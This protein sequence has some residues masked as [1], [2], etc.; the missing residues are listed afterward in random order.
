MKV[1]TYLVLRQ[2][3]IIFS[4][5]APPLVSQQPSQ[6][7]LEYLLQHHQVN[8]FETQPQLHLLRCP[9]TFLLF[10]LVQDI[11]IKSHVT[12]S[13]DSFVLDISKLVPKHVKIIV[14]EVALHCHNIKLVTLLWINTNI[15]KAT[16]SFQVR[17]L[18]F[19]SCPYLFCQLE[20]QG[21]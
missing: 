10:V 7:F 12:M 16:K 17:V 1:N 11:F 9:G 4:T 5:P 18:E 13:Q 8:F 15:C 6:E 14:Y 19:F 2:F 3:W 21:Y 20:T